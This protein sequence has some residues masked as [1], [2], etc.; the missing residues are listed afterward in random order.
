ML[1][2]VG[3]YWWSVEA[4]YPWKHVMRL[5]ML[6]RWVI[7]AALILPMGCVRFFAAER[8]VDCRVAVAGILQRQRRLRRDHHRQDERRRSQGARIRHRIF[9]YLDIATTVQPIPIQEL[10]PGLQACLRARA[11]CRAF[12]FEPKR[13]YSKRLGNFLLDILEFRRKTHE[14]GWRFKAL[15]VFV[16]HHVA[17]KLYSGEPK[18]DQLQDQINPL[19]PLQSPA[20]LVTSRVPH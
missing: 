9:A 14:T 19:G 10:D 2:G 6:P 17:Y 12:I 4:I 18:I 3:S 7:C 5:D 8:Q 13:T 11:D 15:I 1:T 20:S 16:N